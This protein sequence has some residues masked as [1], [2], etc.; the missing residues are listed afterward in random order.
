MLKEM[1]LDAAAQHDIAAKAHRAAAE[2]NDHND[3]EAAVKHA[4]EA[5]NY[6]TAAYDLSEKA[7][8]HSTSTLPTK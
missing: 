5:Q 4:A 2:H 7:L 6:S 1:H 3:A 8:A